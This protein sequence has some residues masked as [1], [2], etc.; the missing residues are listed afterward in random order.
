MISSLTRKEVFIFHRLSVWLLIG[1]NNG[2][3][4]F[5]VVQR[6]HTNYGWIHLETLV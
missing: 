5:P 6:A 1:Y 3:S 4:C 2:V